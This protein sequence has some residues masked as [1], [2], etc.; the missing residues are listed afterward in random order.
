M[1]QTVRLKICRFLYLIGL[2]LGGCASSDVIIDHTQAFQSYNQSDF[3]LA[4][5]QFEQLTR[6]VPKDAELW[7]KMGNACAKA[8]LYQKAVDAYQNALLRDPTMEKAWYNMGII[9]MQNALNTFIEMDQYGEGN[10]PRPPQGALYA[11][12][13]VPVAARL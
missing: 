10:T 6:K 13:S 4:C 9:Q 1:K 3:P 8:E 12:R 11:R 7:F 2:T 5:E